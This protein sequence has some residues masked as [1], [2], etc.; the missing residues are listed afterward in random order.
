MP[1]SLSLITA[2]VVLLGG[3]EAMA[4]DR[5]LAPLVSEPD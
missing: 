1:R 2:G 5:A 3:G 4:Q